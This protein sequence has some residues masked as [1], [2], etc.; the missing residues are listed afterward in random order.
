MV[1]EY[2]TGLAEVLELRPVRYTYNGTDVS[3]PDPQRDK[4]LARESPI[5]TAT[6]TRVARDGT[7]YIGLIAQEA[8]VPMPEM[9]TQTS[10][11]IDGVPVDDY[12]VMDTGSL[13]YRTW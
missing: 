6:I 4:R 1:G 8:E 5:P 9:V 3:R 10:A 2:E 11:E 13:V 12:R 7:E